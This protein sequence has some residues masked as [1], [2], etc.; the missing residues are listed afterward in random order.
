MRKSEHAN[1]GRRPMSRDASGARGKRAANAKPDAATPR[2]ALARLQAGLEREEAELPERIGIAMLEACGELGY[3]A[4]TVRDVIERYGGYRLQFYRL[5]ANKAECYELSYAAEAERLCA[6]LLRAGAEQPDWRAALRTALATLARYI[7]ERGAAA[8][9]LLVEVHV[10]GGGALEKKREMS[11]RLTRAIDSARRETGSRHSPP[12]MTAVFMI[13]AIEA[14][15]C[16]ALEQG[17]PER[18]AA[19]VPELAQMVVAAYFGERA[20]QDELSLAVVD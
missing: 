12:P 15:V 4:V 3:R 17:E 2:R 19:A 5:F 1:A 10:A 9:G 18:F 13:S 8:R 7:D 14:S 16:E 20:A 11:E 6:A